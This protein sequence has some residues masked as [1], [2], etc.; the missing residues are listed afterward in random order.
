MFSPLDKLHVITKKGQRVREEKRFSALF[1]I[2]EMK[3]IHLMRDD[4]S[5]IGPWDETKRLMPLMPFKV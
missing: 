1:Y 4:P 3:I 2:L 5:A